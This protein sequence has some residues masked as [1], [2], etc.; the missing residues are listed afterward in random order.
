LEWA[1]IGA[2]PIVFSDRLV[3]HAECSATSGLSPAT[4]FLGLGLGIK[5]PSGRTL[6][7]DS[8]LQ[9]YQSASAHADPLLRI[10]LHGPAAMTGG[11]L[12]D[13]KRLIEN[14]EADIAAAAAACGC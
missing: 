10:A 14:V 11:R 13:L 7:G 6:W 3:V 9:C 5:Q 4:L 12:D 2:D 1:P 8:V